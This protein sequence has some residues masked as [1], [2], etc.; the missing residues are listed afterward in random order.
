MPHRLHR[1]AL[2][3]H[4]R[5]LRQ[6]TAVKLRRLDAEQ[7]PWFHVGVLVSSL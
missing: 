6:I 1:I 3:R 7:R 5:A 4:P 2:D